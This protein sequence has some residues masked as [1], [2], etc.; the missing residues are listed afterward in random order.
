M[1][2]ELPSIPSHG[3]T[4][5]VLFVIAV[6]ILLVLFGSLCYCLVARRSKGTYHNDKPSNSSVTC[7]VF[8]FQEVQEA[9]NNF[10]EDFL[11]GIGGF[12]NVYKGKLENGTKVAVKRATPLST[13]GLSEFQ[14]EIQLLSKLQHPHIVSLVGYCHEGEEMILVYEYM[15][16]GPL[17]KWFYEQCESP[18]SWKQRLEICIGAAKGLHYL[19]TSSVEGIIHR[20]VKTANI[21]LDENFVAKVADFGISKKGS[22]LDES[23]VVTSV[24]GT[25]GY[26]DPEYFRTSHLT[27][28]SDVYSFGV[29]L[30]EV[31]SGRPALDH[32]LPT[33]KINVATWAM[34][35]EVKGQLHQIMDPNIVGKA[36]VSSLNKVWEV[37]KRCLAENRINRPPIGFVLCCLEDALHLELSNIA[38]EENSFLNCEMSEVKVS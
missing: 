16:N 2:F 8:T 7:R 38:D 6:S 31:I 34:N 15:A 14:N 24:K 35:S 9:T 3:S 18:L 36:R 33:E 27:E 37:A 10:Q 4:S 21:L 12:G 30:I 13:Q 11:L 32:G 25:F 29:V 17:S 19:H 20:D 28:K 1:A 5:T 26:I 22:S 23:L